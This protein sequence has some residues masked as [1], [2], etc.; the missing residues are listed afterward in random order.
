MWVRSL[1]HAVL[2][3]HEG[4][5]GCSGCRLHGLQGTELEGAKRPK[6]LQAT[7]VTPVVPTASLVAPEPQAVVLQQ[8]ANRQEAQLLAEVGA[9]R[10]AVV[11]GGGQRG[12]HE[13]QTC[14]TSSGRSVCCLHLNRLQPQLEWMHPAAAWPAVLPHCGACNHVATQR[15]HC[16][17]PSAPATRCGCR[18]ASSMHTS[19]PAEW[20]TATTRSTPRA[21]SR[22][23]AGQQGSRE[24]AMARDNGCEVDK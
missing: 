9:P 11:G 17:P 4:T 12:R 19:A 7:S 15:V 23:A 10:E 6:Q 13:A 1:W 24:G 14:S 5:R 21:S 22:P 2:A 20:P 3:R 8:A 18:C 16:E